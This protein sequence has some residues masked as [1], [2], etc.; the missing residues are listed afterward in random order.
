LFG[1]HTGSKLETPPPGRKWIKT[2]EI[3]P[4]TRD[5]AWDRYGISFGK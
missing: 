3:T 5:A 1:G 4:G 2:R